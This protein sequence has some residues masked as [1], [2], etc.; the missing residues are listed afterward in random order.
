MTISTQSPNAD[1]AKDSDELFR[2]KVRAQIM[3]NLEEIE[4]IAAERATMASQ[5]EKMAAERETMASQREKMAAETEKIVA[6]SAACS[7]RGSTTYIPVGERNDGG[8]KGKNGVRKGS[9]ESAD[10]ENDGGNRENAD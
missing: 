1:P 4:K 5:R 8:G 6:E 3:R 10:N 2:E 9:G 7:R